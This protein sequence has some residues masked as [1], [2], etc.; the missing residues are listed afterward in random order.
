MNIISVVV[1]VDCVVVVVVVLLLWW[2]M[3]KSCVVCCGVGGVWEMG[4]GIFVVLCF[5]DGDG[6]VMVMMVVTVVVVVVVIII[7][8]YYFQDRNM[9][10]TYFVHF[11]HYKNKYYSLKVRF[12]DKRQSSVKCLLMTKSAK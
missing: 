12:R 1:V 6:V 5:G 11:L 3:G 10:L 2:C 8:H 7:I 4:C 9:S